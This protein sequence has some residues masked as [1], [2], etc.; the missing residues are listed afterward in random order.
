MEP[1]AKKTPADTTE[2]ER[3]QLRFFLSQTDVAETLAELNPSLA[4]LSELARMKVFQSASQLTPWIEK[5][6]G[7][8]EAVR[9]ISANLDFFDDRAAVMLEHALKRWRDTMPPLL[10]KS[11]RLIIRHIRE[12]PRGAL[13]SEWFE[14]Q[15]RIKAREHSAELLERLAS[16]LRPKP[17]VGKRVSWS[18]QDR[19]E[20]V[21]QRPSDLVSVD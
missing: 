5:N 1:K 15:P 12:N 10:A 11:W 18:A 17:K 19:G 9:E 2:F 6:F 8:P 7:D 14:I 21:P 3:E 13:R 16:V 20:S 4:W